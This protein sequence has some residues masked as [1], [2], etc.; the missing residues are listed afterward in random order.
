MR[1]L[2]VLTSKLPHNIN[3]SPK[4]SSQEKVMSDML[5][6]VQAWLALY[7]LRVVGA[8][9]ILILGFI[10]AKLVRKGAVSLL[11]R[12]NVDETLV[13]FAGGL[14]KFILGA[15][16][17]IAALE[18][19]GFSTG[20]L[21][22]VLGAASL[23]V[24]L[25]LQGQLANLAAGVLIL[26]FRPFKVGHL[27]NVGGSLGTV[28]GISMLTTNLKT[29]D[30]QAVLIPNSQ[31]VSQ[32]ITNLSAKPIRRVDLVV[33]IGYEDDL[34]EAK[35]VLS[36]MLQSEPRVLDDPPIWVGVLE[37][38]DSS[39][40]LGARGWVNTADWWQTLTDLTEQ[41]KLRLDA[42]GISIPFPQRDIHLIKSDS[43][44]EAA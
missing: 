3:K 13:G 37:L 24:G 38:A 31:V 1:V 5:P 10:A 11:R 2:L 17:L 42:K 30:G 29:P 35:A 19:V 28:E 34:S 40:N 25:A 22:A 6:Q 16:V 41:A 12:A 20:S 44:A 32:T 9:A 23:A 43:Q 4:N 15:L 21:I 7:G 39:V 8:L 36:E 14:L 26:L 18:Q 27:V 33:G